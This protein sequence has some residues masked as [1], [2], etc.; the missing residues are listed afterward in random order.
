MYIGN[1]NLP[2]GSTFGKR[3]IGEE[4]AKEAAEKA[5]DAAIVFGRR[6]FARQADRPTTRESAQ[7]A[8]VFGDRMRQGAVRGAVSVEELEDLLRKNPSFFDSL[9]DLELGRPEGPRTAALRVF[10]GI[11]LGDGGQQRPEVIQELTDLLAAVG[12]G[13]DRSTS[14]RSEATSSSADVV[15]S[16]PSG[17]QPASDM[18]QVPVTKSAAPN[19]EHAAA[20]ARSKP[21]ATRRGAEKP[22]TERDSA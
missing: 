17:T 8:S 16:S 7:Q 11:E 21:P 20:Q 6:V 18:E 22:R 2:V 9:Y 13:S 15:E 14:E 12:N 1:T 10:L 19:V 3:V 5:Q 4:A